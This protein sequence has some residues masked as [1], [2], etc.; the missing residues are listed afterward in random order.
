MVRDLRI[1]LVALVV[2]CAPGAPAPAQDAD[3]LA[4]P[5]DTLALQLEQRLAENLVPIMQ[6]FCYACHGDTKTKGDVRFQGLATLDDILAT[7]D[8]WKTARELIQT[9]EMPPEDE[10]APSDLQRLILIQWIDDALAYTPT[11]GAIDPGWFTIHRLNKAEYR[12]TLRDL[13]GIDPAAADLAADLPPDDTGYGFDNIADVLSMSPLQVELYLDAA[14]RAVSLGLGP[15]VEVSTEPKPI[16]NLEAPANGSPLGSGFA[17]YA[18]GEVYGWAEVPAAGD[19]EIVIETWGQRAG[20]ELPRLSIRVDDREVGERSV[21]AQRGEIEEARARLRLPAGRHK[22]AGAFTND[23]YIPDTADRNLAIESICLAGPLDADTLDR[24][25][26]YREIFFTQPAPGAGEP[27]QR[28][29]ARKVIAR[30][31]ERAFRRPL[32]DDEFRRLMKVYEASRAAGD[33]YEQAARVTLAATLVSPHFLYRSLAN[34][35]SNDPAHTYELTDHELASRLSYFLWSTMPDAELLAAAAEGKLRDQATLRAQARRMLADPRADAFIDNFAG[36]WLLLR[37]LDRLE[38][39]T[40]TYADYTT[41]L[42]ADMITEATMFFADIVRSDRPLLDL[43]D[44][45]ESFLNERLAR[46]YAIPGVAGN[47]F[48][49]VPLPPDSPRGGILT[50]GAVLTV[51]SNPTRTSPVKR[52]LY[53]LDELLG[54]P[55]PPPPPNIPRLEQ[56]ASEAALPDDAPLRDK[57]A[58]HLLDPTCITCHRRMDPIGLA[59]ENFDAIGRWRDDDGARPIDAS[60]ELPGGIAFDGP[61]ELKHILL[62]RADDFIENLSRKVLTYAL[63]RGLEPFDR[64]TVRQITDRVR[65]EG[66]TFGALVEAVV[67]SPAFR[68]CRG[69]EVT[70]E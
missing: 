60:G 51:T 34:R 40:T 35:H 6:E 3:P 29:T 27:A 19:Y 2:V 17:M 10:P 47:D 39:D 28:T 7:A 22:I 32:R 66:D 68:T 50:M 9:G 1:S 55:P 49:R 23:F 38:I 16:G 52:G 48:R 21:E 64:P 62:T 53:V 14:E 11:D 45:R 63:G 31:A 12:N 58:A 15:I 4:P 13:L 33:T 61:I 5:P 30:F 41:E 44:S 67:S 54:A 42:R 25:A 56:S 20:D 37:N 26:A 69:R 46:H 24:P 65:A 57:L 18:N 36:Q 8:T 43:L 70:S 59:M